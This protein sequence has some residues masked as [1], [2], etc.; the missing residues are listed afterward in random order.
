MQ[1]EIALRLHRANEQ[2]ILQMQEI[3]L[4]N[5]EFTEFFKLSE[6]TIVKKARDGSVDDDEKEQ[7]LGSQTEM[8]NVDSQLRMMNLD[9]VKANLAQAK[10]NQKRMATQI[11]QLKQK[12]EKASKDAEYRVIDNQ[13]KTE[14]NEITKLTKDAQFREKKLKA[15]QKIADDN[16]RAGASAADLAILD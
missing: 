1:K 3:N 12:K 15:E 9:K 6:N 11:Q 5:Q 8:A 14:K 13:I 7:V 2:I 10:A 16:R 4:E